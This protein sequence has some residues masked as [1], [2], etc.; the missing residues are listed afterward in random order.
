MVAAGAA[1]ESVPLELEG[2][3]VSLGAGAAAEELDEESLDGA[4]GAAAAVVVVVGATVVV[5]VTVV[6]GTDVVVVLSGGTEWSFG[7]ALFFIDS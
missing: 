2:V 7:P 3:A 5:G 1:P 4:T 6:L